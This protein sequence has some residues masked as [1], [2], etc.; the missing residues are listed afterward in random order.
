MIFNLLFMQQTF[1]EFDAVLLTAQLG[2]CL[3]PV[4]KGRAGTL[5]FI[6]GR[7]TS[8]LFG[9][10]VNTPSSMTEPG[11][12]R[13]KWNNEPGNENEPELSGQQP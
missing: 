13:N 12:F 1:D 6:S 2:P 11:K 8:N 10:R 7:S 5:G 4:I 9:E 3:H